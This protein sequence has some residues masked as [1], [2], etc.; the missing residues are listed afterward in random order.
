M[1]APSKTVSHTK[2]VPAGKPVATAK[3]P[4][5]AASSVAPAPKKKTEIEAL[6]PIEIA[7]PA[8]IAVVVAEPEPEITV[9]ATAEPETVLEAA[10]VVPEPTP[11][12]VETK[13]AE[14]AN[15]KTTPQTIATITSEMKG[16]QAMTD[17]IETTKKF[18][19][20]AKARFQTVFTEIGEKAKSGVEKSTKAFEELGDIAKGNV[21][22]LMESSKIAAKGAEGMGQSAAEYGRTSFEKASATMKSFASVKSP[23]EFFQLQSELLSSSFDSFAKES[24]KSSEALLKLAGDVVQPLSTRVSIVTEKVKSLAS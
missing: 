20:E 14:Q 23:A 16:T 24:A 21:E 9:P 4:T 18:T 17:V 1:V 8:A 5:K 6:A 22:A 11:Q 12:A 19:E 13:I 15:V 3:G 10:P 7:P 2:A